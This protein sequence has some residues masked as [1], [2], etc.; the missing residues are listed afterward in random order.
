MSL[1]PHLRQKRGASRDGFL[2]N[3]RLLNSSDPRVS[4]R[5][6]R[7][8]QEPDGKR[9]RHAA[10]RR[11]GRQAILG[12]DPPPD[13]HQPGHYSGYATGYMHDFIAQ[14]QRRV[15]RRRAEILPG[16][17]FAKS[18]DIGRLISPLRYDIWVRIE[19]IRLLRD[20]WSVYTGDLQQFLERP[21]S[22]AYYVWFHE[23]FCARYKPQ[24]YGQEK[25]VRHAFVER[26][27]DTA[28]L[29]ESIDG[30]GYDPSRPIRLESGR[31]IRSVNGKVIDSTYFAGDGC[32][33]M[34]CLFLMGQTRLEPGQYNVRVHRSFQ[35]LD[36]TAV[37]LKHL[38]LDRT[39]YL[40]FISRFY[41]RDG[42]ELKSA[43]EI[44]QHV[45]RERPN[46]LPELKSVI[47]FDL[48]RILANE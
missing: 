29:W 19:F 41:C 14:V 43:D 1:P 15:A 11:Q 33:R 27:R 45:A 31:S 22:H 24:I 12:I 35:P 6:G 48:S 2:E 34:S 25:L 42:L 4:R 7:V 20:A 28:A 26:V 8:G 3:T 9:S 47:A 5:D 46:L 40:T 18:V 38:P 32:H 36:N 44:L 37:L 30:Q 17:E 10:D 21:E 39:T 16:I 13:V 23:V